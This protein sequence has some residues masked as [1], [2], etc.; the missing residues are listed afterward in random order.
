VGEDAGGGS[1]ASSAAGRRGALAWAAAGRKPPSLPSPTR[2]EAILCP[3]RGE[4]LGRLSPPKRSKDP[5]LPSRREPP[6]RKVD[7][8]DIN[9]SPIVGEDA[10]GGSAAGSGAGRTGALAWAAAGRKPPS[11]PSPTRGEAILCPCR[12]EDL[13]RLSPPMSS[14]DPVLPSTREQPRRKVDY[15]DINPSPLV[16]EGIIFFPHFG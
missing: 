13:G 8:R 14:K 5:V 10:G 15:R 1:A 11:L 12:G 6:R 7:Y 16:G 2:G 9:P 4:H 3:C